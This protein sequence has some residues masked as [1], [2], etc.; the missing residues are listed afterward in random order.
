MRPLL[1]LLLALFLSCGDP[2]AFDGGSGGGSGGGSNGSGGGG[3]SSDDLPCDVADVVTRHCISCHGATP[4]VGAPMP[5]VTRADFL[6]P[7]LLVPQ[8]NYAQRSAVR[9]GST[10]SPMPPLPYVQLTAAERDTFTT[11]ASSDTPA[12][13]CATGVPDGGSLTPSPTTCENNST[14]TGNLNGS[15]HMNPGLACRSCHLGDNFLGQNPTGAVEAFRAY[16]FMGTVFPLLHERDRCYG[17]PPSNTVVEI[18]DK[19][20]AVALRMQAAPP[21]G[22]FFSTST[23]AG[24]QLP[25]TAR[26]LA[27]GKSVTMNT[28][29]TNGDCNTC[30]TEQ[31]LSGAPGRIVWPK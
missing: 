4:T 16:F 25:Y 15:S 10:N 19:N 9:V 7:S 6:K 24:V 5:L 18:L 11:W 21:S 26:V 14:W 17:A 31:G 12:G 23:M 8:L 3:A 1:V 30:H 22:N 28:P 2:G 20:G 13:P 29:Q 27:N